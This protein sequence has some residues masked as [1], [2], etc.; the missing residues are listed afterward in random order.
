MAEHDAQH[1]QEKNWAQVAA[2]DDEAGFRALVDPHMET[3]LDAAR[4]DLDYYRAQGLLH[5]R[6]LTPEEVVGEGLLHAWSRRDR[7]PEA[8]R[9]KA[10]LLGTQHRAVRGLVND[11]RTYRAEKAIS[12]DAPIE[13]QPE[14]YAREQWFAEWY[15][16][17]RG[18][19][20]WEEVTPGRAPQD[21]EISLRE[22]GHA[23]ALDPSSYHVLML[24]DEFDLSLPD[25]AFAM[26][27][28]VNEVAEAVGEARVTLRERLG[29]AP[30]A[31]VPDPSDG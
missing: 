3:L 21:L 10:W 4:Q 25:I 12:L 22:T 7:K 15:E 8:M 24:H 27:R 18:G 6:D 11:I 23:K 26:G 28:S 1:E 20:T 9:L 14:T 31:A 16:P 17:N 29:E 5:E 30:R 13:P 19:L 2:Q